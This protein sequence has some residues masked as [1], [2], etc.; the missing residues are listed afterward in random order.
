MQVFTG[1]LGHAYAAVYV[2]IDV[3]DYSTCQEFVSSASS[4]D[5]SKTL[6]RI[7]IWL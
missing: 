2:V 7:R 6:T 3:E 5:P 1:M 4:D